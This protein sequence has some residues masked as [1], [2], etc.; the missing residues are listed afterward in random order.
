MAKKVGNTY[1]FT[2]K[3]KTTGGGGGGGDATDAIKYT[4]QTLS[5]EQQMQARKNQGL[6]YEE[7]GTEEMTL[8]WDGDT[9]GRD[10]I[11]WYGD[12]L[13]KIA[14]FPDADAIINIV[15][16][17]TMQNGTPHSQT[18]DPPLRVEDMSDSLVSGKYL[19]TGSFAFAKDAVLEQGG[20]SHT[21]VYFL[22]MSN[23]SM[24][25]YP[26]SCTFNVKSSSV[27]QIPPKYIPQTVPA[28]KIEVPSQSSEYYNIGHT[29]L[30]NF[31]R[32]RDVKFSVDIEG[33][34]ISWLSIVDMSD[35]TATHEGDL[36]SDTYTF[37]S[38]GSYLVTLNLVDSEENSRNIS[39]ILV[40][41]DISS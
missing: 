24:T 20:Q 1:F 26:S 37:T 34:R 9:T 18:F 6:Y 16:A 41:V 28:V 30:N 32:S 11:D 23:S 8:T 12:T 33:F 31:V 40:V 13:Y 35:P 39:A 38:A 2:G 4:A 5:E 3:G 17:I 19:S 22:L 36:D 29:V 14:D 21:G 27:H 10:M 25:I 15:A 7:E